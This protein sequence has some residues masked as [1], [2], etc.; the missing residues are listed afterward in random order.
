[1]SKR[2]SSSITF[3]V[4]DGKED[5]ID[6]MQK[7]AKMDGVTMN[8]IYMWA[9]EEYLEKHGEGNPQTTLD[10]HGEE[11]VSAKEAEGRI[12][13][14]LKARADKHG[15]ISFKIILVLITGE[16]IVGKT[17]ATMAQRIAEDLKEQGVK[18]Y[19]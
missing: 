14:N 9:L 6:G 13:A 7:L 15:E 16:G 2:A 4:P 1:M 10:G 17:R 18:V 3:H 12:R 5:V 8:V 19:Y 11:D